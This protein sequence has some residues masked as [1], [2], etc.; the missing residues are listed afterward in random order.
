[1][2]GI[3]TGQRLDWFANSS[4]QD[5]FNARQVV[6]GYEQAQKI[7]DEASDWLKWLG[8]SR[9]ARRGSLLGP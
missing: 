6:N 2:C 3:Y 7:A 5:F 1:V 9:Q 8:E 4:K